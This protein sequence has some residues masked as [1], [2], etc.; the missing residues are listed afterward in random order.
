MSHPA[1]VRDDEIPDHVYHRRW[2]ILGVLCTSLLVIVLANTS[3][4]VALPTMAREL[5]LSTSAQQWVVDAY[6]LVFAGLLFTAGTLGDRF[7]RKGFLQAGLVLFA[8]GSAYATFV[9]STGG[10]VIAARAVMG[11]GGALV[12]PATLS[13]LVNSFPSHERARAIAIWAGVSGAGGA[14]GL[15]LGGWLVEHYWWG[16]T[17]AMNLPVIAL[18]FVIGTRILP[19]SKD[20]HP[21][22]ID[23]PGSILSMAGLGALVYGLIEAPHWGWTSAST[24][25]ALG[26]SVLLLVGFVAWELHTPEPMLDMTLFRNRAFGVSSLGVTMVFLVMFGFFFV[27]VQLFQLLFGY[28]PFES[29][30]RMLPFIPVMIVMTTASPRLVERFGT[31]LVV[32]VGMTVTGVGV[33]LL[34]GLNAAS[35]YGEVL[36]GMFV[37]AAGMGLTMTPMTDLIMSSVPRDKAGVGSA[38]NDTT[39]ELGTT[40]GVAILGSILS[41]TY[42]SHLGSAVGLLPPEVRSIASGSLGGALAVSQQIGGDTGARFADAAKSAWADGVHVSFV[43]G[44]VIVFVAAAISFAFLDRKAAPVEAVELDRELALVD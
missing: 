32:S 44:A 10:E 19:T 15:V 31:R 26:I 27:V 7:G 3:M 41:S 1:S 36:V 11:V 14:V 28:G 16:S 13:I 33:L 23:V 2:V 39:R 5:G 30:L 25:I 29:G 20:P 9:A 8:L 35:T 17:F 24:A 6:A 42:A 12:M 22:A 4:N 40:L 37:M 21:S 18:S 34:S 43:V 38:M